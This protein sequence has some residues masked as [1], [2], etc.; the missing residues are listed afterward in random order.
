MVMHT[1]I[2]FTI[3]DGMPIAFSLSMMNCQLTVSNALLI[4]T[5]NTHITRP[6]DRW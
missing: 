4:S 1:S 5:F 6:F 2:Q 3:V